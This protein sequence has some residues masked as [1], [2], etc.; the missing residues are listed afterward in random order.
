MGHFPIVVNKIL[1]DV[2][3]EEIAALLAEDPDYFNHLTYDEVVL[4]LAN[5]K[6]LADR[7]FP[8]GTRRPDEAAG[9]PRAFFRIKGTHPVRFAP[10]VRDAFRT[11]FNTRAEAVS[12]SRSAGGGE[13]SS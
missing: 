9:D 1:P 3:P 6:L 4:A 5:V 2:P 13:G 8:E 7:L 12:A 11:D 10:G